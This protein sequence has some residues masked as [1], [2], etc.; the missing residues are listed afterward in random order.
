MIPGGELRARREALGLTVEA[1]AKATK[2]PVRYLE[3]LEDERYGD[4]PAGPYAEAYTRTVSLHLG[5]RPTPE[6]DAGDSQ[7]A[8]PVQ[9][10]PLWFVRAMAGATLSVLAAMLGWFA[11][12]LLPAETDE[13]AGGP[14]QEVVIRSPKRAENLKIMVDGVSQTQEL[15][16]FGGPAMQVRGREIVI[17]AQVVGAVEI[18]WNGRT[19]K[20]LGRQSGRRILRFVD[21]GA[22]TP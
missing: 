18:Q 15:L 20:P 13:S 1:V 2:I 3:A 8:R 14:L 5:L 17:D 10:A 11:W 22:V 7:D 19:V 9:R 4:L 16:Y 21:D 12:G 6:T